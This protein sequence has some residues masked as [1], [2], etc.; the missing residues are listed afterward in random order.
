MAL[1]RVAARSHLG[2]YRAGVMNRFGGRTIGC[3]P[4]GAIY[5]PDRFSRRAKQIL[6]RSSVNV[7]TAFYG[8]CRKSVVLIRKT[9]AA[10]AFVATVGQSLAVDR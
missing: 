10:H 4:A 3:K 5:P 6:E 7:C 1:P 8:T 2:E 9:Q